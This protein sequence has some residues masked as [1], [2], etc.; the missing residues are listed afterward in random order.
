MSFSLARAGGRNGGIWAAV[1]SSSGEQLK[2]SLAGG[3]QGAAR[4]GGQGGARGPLGGL[5]GPPSGTA[6]QTFRVP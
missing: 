2:Q 1:P 6:M 3:H 4:T 5:A